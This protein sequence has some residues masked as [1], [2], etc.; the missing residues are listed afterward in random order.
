MKRLLWLLL[1]ASGWALGQRE[2]RVVAAS[3]LQYA[4]PEIAQA[5]Q[6]E[7]PGV[8]V[9]LA[10]GSSGR[11]YTQL[12]QGLEADLFFS[13]ESLYP[14]LLEERGLAERGSRRLYALGRLVVWLDRRLGL[15]P[16]PQALKDPRVTQLAIANPVHAPYGR[17]AITLLERY[18][19]LKRRPD[20]PIPGLAKPF[21]QLAWAEIPWESLTRGVEA[22]WDAE[23]LRRGKPRFAFVYGENIA[24]AAQLAVAAT[25]AGILALPLAIHESLS[26]PGVFWLAPMG[27]HLLLEQ[28]YVVLKGRARPEVLAFHRFVGSPEGRAIF[29]RYGFLLPGE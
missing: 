29:R 27:S 16:G 18:G 4:L 22:Y 7:N 25:Q 3:D 6:A 15:E 2:V 21:A 5:F 12:T 23:P 13:A 9:R 26:R 28:T 10:F 11:L 24:H 1:L 14:R 8:Q 19:L 17:A 20:A